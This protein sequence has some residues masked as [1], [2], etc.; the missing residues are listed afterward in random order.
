MDSHIYENEITRACAEVPEK[1]IGAGL[2]TFS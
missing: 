1:E 2:P